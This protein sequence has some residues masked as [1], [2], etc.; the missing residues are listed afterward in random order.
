M[1]PSFGNVRELLTTYGQTVNYH[2]DRNY[3]LEGSS[4]A[5]CQESG[6]W[7]YNSGQPY[8]IGTTYYNRLF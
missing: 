5:T 8:C 4:S 7:A 3:K 6:D 2:C 1:I